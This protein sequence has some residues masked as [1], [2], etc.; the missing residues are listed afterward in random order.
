MRNHIVSLGLIVGL[1]LSPTCP[2]PAQSDSTIAP[3]AKLPAQPTAIRWYHVGA[4]LGV[5]A[6]ATLVDES[7]RDRIQRHRTSTG[8]DVAHA[9][10]HMGEPLVYG[11]VGLGTIAVGLLAGNRPLARAGERISAGLLTAAFVTTILKETVG[12][13]RPGGPAD[14]FN[15]RPFSGKDSWPSGH[16]TM[17]FALATGMSD[18]IHRLPVSVLLYG[19]ATLTA[20]SRL[21]DDR[22]WLSDVITGAAVGV[23][24]T[25]LM[26]GHWRVLGIRGPRF[27]L[28]PKAVGVTLRF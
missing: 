19:A 2:L 26:N 16:S 27:L 28:E 17:A 11:T 3:T 7:L 21:N 4:G 20:W 8:D 23:T 10:R 5:V 13:R 14:A 1:L 12:R 22:H 18:E 9:F 24:S 6:A 25:K 15:F